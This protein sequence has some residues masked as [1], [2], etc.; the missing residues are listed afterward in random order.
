MQ[1]REDQLNAILQNLETVNSND[2]LIKQAL[3]WKEHIFKERDIFQ[4]PSLSELHIPKI[5]P[6]LPVI[7]LAAG[8]GEL[9]EFYSE[10]NISNKIFSDTLFDVGRVMDECKGRN[11]SFVIE[12]PI[13]EWLCKHFRAQLFHIGRLQYEVIQFKEDNEFLKKGDYVINIHIPAGGRMPYEEVCD[14]YRQAAVFFEKLMPDYPIKYFICETWMLSPQLRDIL[15]GSSN[16]IQFLNDY[17]LYGTSE[18]EG[19]YDSIF[20]KKPKDLNSLSEKTSLQRAIKEHLLS[21]KK[22]LSGR[23]CHLVEKWK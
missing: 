1:L 5:A 10:N 4:N 2:S 7:V 13:F 23:G 14:S 22:L 19:F 16:L 18:D 15:D 20:I 21:G 3:S 17:E 9:K 6:L 11:G 8:L 12:P